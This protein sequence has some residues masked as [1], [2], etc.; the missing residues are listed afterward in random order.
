[1][2]IGGAGNPCA[3]DVLFTKSVPHCPHIL[4]NI[5]L[6]LDYKSYK[7]C[8]EVNNTWYKLLASESFQRK[9]KSVFCDGILQDNEKL[10]AF[11]SLVYFIV[12]TKKLTSLKVLIPILPVKDPVIAESNNETS[13]TQS[14]AKCHVLLLFWS[15]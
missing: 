1:M 12:G 9:A 4:E 11:F 14:L 13:H 3:F 10:M 7:T 5:F 8:F 15:R 6:S 2:D